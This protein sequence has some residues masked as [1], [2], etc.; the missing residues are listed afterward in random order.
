[1]NRYFTEAFN[2]PS[3]DELPEYKIFDE[4]NGNYTIYFDSLDSYIRIDV[5]KDK[6]KDGRYDIEF[7]HKD[8]LET[9]DRGDYKV[10]PIVFALIKKLHESHPENI[11]E[12]TFSS[13]PDEKERY[14]IGNDCGKNLIDIVTRFRKDFNLKPEHIKRIESIITN[15]KDGKLVVADTIFLGFILSMDGAEELDD[16]F[17]NLWDEIKHIPRR[18]VIYK[19]LLVRY[20]G[21]NSGVTFDCS[22]NGHVLIRFKTPTEKLVDEANHWM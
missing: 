9:S 21:G 22:R 5:K 19:N 18:P 15:A 2:L 20:F 3:D 16:R 10:I 13:N 11:K 8:S 12:I 4:D 14:E 6:N 7:R 1:M 17:Q